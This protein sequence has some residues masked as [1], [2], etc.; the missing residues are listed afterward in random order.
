MPANC[1][2][3]STNSP[4]RACNDV[5]CASCSVLPFFVQDDAE[6]LLDREVPLPGPAR[7]RAGHRRGDYGETDA[8][9]QAFRRGVMPVDAV[10][11]LLGEVGASQH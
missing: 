7:L 8:V 5:I 9:Y 4:T 1:S 11:E 10:T 3:A 6:T 2:F